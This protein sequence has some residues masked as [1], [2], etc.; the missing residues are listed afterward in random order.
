VWVTGPR[1]MRLRAHFLSSSKPHRV[2]TPFKLLC[3]SWLARGCRWQAPL[4]QAAVFCTARDIELDKNWPR[5]HCRCGCSSSLFYQNEKDMIMAAHIQAAQSEESLL[6]RGGRGKERWI[7]N[8]NT[9][10]LSHWASRLLVR[11]LSDF[12]NALSAAWMHARRIWGAGWQQEEKEVPARLVCSFSAARAN[13]YIE[14]CITKSSS[15]YLT[16]TFSTI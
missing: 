14:S 9:C 16:H 13:S 5:Q 11:R 4:L 3:K 1:M 6:S 10:T 12:N 15:F 7:F 8:C 2:Y